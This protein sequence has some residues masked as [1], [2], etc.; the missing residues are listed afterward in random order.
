MRVGVILKRWIEVLA[1]LLFSCHEAWRSRRSLIVCC[2]TDGL[3]IRQVG[4]GTARE[5]TM[6]T[7]PVGTPAPNEVVQIAHKGL[8]V[9]EL[10]PEKIT[11][12]RIGV[13]TKAREFLPG[14]IRNLIDRL[15]PWQADQAI[16]GFEAKASPEDPTALDVV[17]VVTSRAIVDAAREEVATIGLVVDRIIVRESAGDTVAPVALWSRVADAP[18]VGADH[19]HRLIG[20]AIAGCVA[21]SFVVSVLAVMS[22]VSLRNSSEDAESRSETLQRQLHLTRNAVVNA[23]LDPAES[24]WLAKQ[25]TPSAVV[26]L[27]ELSR[28]LPDT[29][30]LTDLQLEH[31]T[32]RIIGL[33]ADAPSLVAPLER[34]GHFSGVHFFAPTTRDPDA[35]LYQFHIEAQVEPRLQLD[36]D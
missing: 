25:S 14:I 30:Y 33:A 16:Y 22:A 36:K 26:S 21:L 5:E 18:R 12:R 20:M 13:P 1:A 6:C 4:A 8:I 27:E 17:V 10:P 2:D 19:A 23:S 7:I 3:R 11:A 15:S 32:M 35:T 31:D 29:S 24:A 28:A 34:S 9:L